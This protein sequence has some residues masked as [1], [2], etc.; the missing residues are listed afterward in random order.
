MI[1]SNESESDYYARRVEERAYIGEAYNG[2]TKRWEIVDVPPGTERVKMD[3]I[4]GAS[5]EITWQ[6]YNGVRRSTFQAERS[7]E[8]S[9]DR[10]YEREEV[11]D[12][13]VGRP[14][15]APPR[16]RLDDK[17]TEITKDLV[18]RE[19][20]KELGYDFEETEFFFYVMRYLSYVS[21][22]SDTYSPAMLIWQ[23]E[24]VQELVLLSED[25]KRDR[26]RRIKQMA[27]ERDRLKE[28]TMLALPA[29]PERR[30]A[31]STYDE[32]R[33]V[34]REIVYDVPRRAR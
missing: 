15:P 8:S 1:G 7:S 12:R 4:G 27:R 13:R 25:I 11:T 5:Q 2:A 10:E 32:E 21:V 29:P 28:P 20:I 16:T 30:R 19:A 26:R 6:R 14:A 9:F 17:W 18:V 33:I 24:D 3:G 31:S 23:K 22:D 34:D